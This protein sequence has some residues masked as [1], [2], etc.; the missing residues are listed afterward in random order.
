MGPRFTR[1][2]CREEA[3]VNIGISVVFQW[4][5]ALRADCVQVKFKP[6]DTGPKTFQWGRALR[7]DCVGMGEMYKEM[8]G[9]EVS[10]GPRFTRGLCR[11][12]STQGVPP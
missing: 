9:E 11:S 4:G 10:M 6:I 3:T 2:L 5:R 1:G 8:Y 7:A 12:F